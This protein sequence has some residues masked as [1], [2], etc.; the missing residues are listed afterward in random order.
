VG[1]GRNSDNNASLALPASSRYA[2]TIL[3]NGGTCMKTGW[4]AALLC[5]M[6]C[7]GCGFFGN[8]RVEVSP[9]CT[10]EEKK[11]DG[12]DLVKCNSAGT[13]WAFYKECD[14]HCSAGGCTSDALPD[15]YSGGDSD[16][17]STPDTPGNGVG[18]YPVIEIGPPG[19]CGKDGDML[20][21]C[22]ANFDLAA[23][24][25][26]EQLILTLSI[27]NSGERS[28]RV[29]DIELEDYAA[30]EGATE[31]SPA[32]VLELPSSFTDAKA[33]DEKFYVAQ[34]NNGTDDTP[35]ILAVRVLF[36]R[37]ADDADRSAVLT[38]KSDASNNPLVKIPLE[39]ALGSPKIQ[40][41]PEWVDFA[42]VSL[43]EEDEKQINILNSGAADLKI[44]GFSLLGSEFYTLE[45]LTTDYPVGGEAVEVTFEDPI[46]IAPGEATFFGVRFAPE[47]SD[48]ANA[49]LTI[50]S[51][52]P[53]T[54]PISDQD[55]GGS[56]VKITA[57]ESVPCIAVNPSKVN[58][59]GKKSGVKAIVPLEI[60]ACGDAPLE[61]QEILMKAGSS[62]DFDLDLSTLDHIPTAEMP[63]IVPI[64]AFATVNVIFI[65]DAPNPTAEDGS[66]ILDTGKVV[67]VNNS[68]ENE[69]EVELSG[70]GVELGCPTSIV[71]CAEGDEVIPQT[72]LH[73]FGDE[74][75]AGNGTI[76]KWEWDVSQ[77]AGSQSLFVPSYT[78]PNPTFE[79]NVAGIYT[80]YLT[81]YDQTN[82][83]S[84]F[85]S[86]YDVLV[87]PDEAIHIELLWHTPEDLDETDTGPEAGSDLDLHFL[88]PWAAGPDLDGDGAA[89][90]WFDIPFDCFWFNAHPNWGNYDPGINDDPGLDRDDTDSA[91]PEIMNFDIPEDVVYRVG[92]HYWNDHGYG[93]SY[94]TVRVYVYAQLVFEVPDIMLDD[95]DMWEVCTIEWP[96][97]KV[98]VITNDAGQYKI[99]PAYYNPYFF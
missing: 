57:N 99:T 3:G 43:G 79:A 17:P 25:I 76:Q 91:G 22:K 59:G 7:G 19:I 64:G 1:K 87:I 96:S 72:V 74:S 41:S 33:A 82:T 71:K 40:V 32:F 26:G 77:P 80:F 2:C 98:Q 85:P 47:S 39:T 54:A 46:V 93:A 58:F 8:D 9:G 12:N 81:V 29:F 89:D 95:S 49:I 36:T 50:F 68:F 75:Y 70:A 11:C 14:E 94:A 18:K 67:I 34:L 16:D 30:G 56:E 35:D 21:N 83:P 23:V 37:P 84:C 15:A 69:K 52:D 66:L 38:I 31:S 65:P 51:N 45:V 61:I 86:E 5:L 63:V 20:S 4:T 24:A 6:V 53:A 44:T 27:K 88:H 73:L 78:F 28:L 97:G 48:P 10:P 62:P 55:V 13:E 42:Q 90:G 60:S 92:V